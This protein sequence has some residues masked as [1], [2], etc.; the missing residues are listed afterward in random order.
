MFARSFRSSKT[1]TTFVVSV[2]IFTDVLLQNL[3]APVLPYALHTQIGLQV[4]ADIQTWTSILL[5]AY[6]AA[7]MLGSC[8]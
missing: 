2:A 8:T 4:E 6:G 7:F 5:S 3:V 1:F